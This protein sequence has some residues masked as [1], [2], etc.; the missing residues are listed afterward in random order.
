MLNYQS[1]NKIVLIIIII[2]SWCPELKRSVTVLH[3]EVSV[4]LPGE[5]RAE[6][7]WPAQIMLC[8]GILGVWQFGSSQLAACDCQGRLSAQACRR[9]ACEPPVGGGCRNSTGAGY[10]A[11]SDSQRGPRT[12]WLGCVILPYVIFYVTILIPGHRS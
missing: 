3:I 11:I 10:A 1:V 2:S 5:E 6:Q 7:G 4:C 12:R 8:S 9:P